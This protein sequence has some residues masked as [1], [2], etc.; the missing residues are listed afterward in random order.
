M[1]RGYP[2]NLG[3]VDPLDL[4][5]EEIASREQVGW[6]QGAPVF[7]VELT[8][9]FS[10][11]FAMRNGRPEMLG[12]GPHTGVTKGIAKKAE[13]RIVWSELQKSDDVVDVNGRI[14]RRYEELTAAIRARRYG[15]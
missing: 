10:F 13:P 5:P 11:V 6:F 1:S 12:Y 9:G 4:R 2:D 3:Y 7:L 8:G 15:R 14:F